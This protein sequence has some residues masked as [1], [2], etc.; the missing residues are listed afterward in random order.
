MM[1]RAALAVAILS[2]LG[3]REARPPAPP[4][5]SPPVAGPVQGWA[6]LDGSPLSPGNARHDDLFFLDALNGWLINTRAEVYRTRDG[7]AS[8]SSLRFGTR[9]NRMRVLNEGL[10]YACGDRVDRWAR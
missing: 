1:S 9:I 10:V 8:W 5:A 2:L 3:C 6:A 4:S 7:G